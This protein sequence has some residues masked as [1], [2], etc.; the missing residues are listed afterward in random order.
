VNEANK[1]RVAK[2]MARG[3]KALPW[4]SFAVGLITGTIMDR[5]PER[6]PFVA[7]AAG[8]GWFAVSA[9]LI[10]GK[11]IVPRLDRRRALA[12]KLIEFSHYSG[13]QTITQLC[14]FFSFPFYLQA[15]SLRVDH[16]IFLVLLAAVAFVSLWDPLY[17]AV[18]ARTWAR[19]PVQ[20]FA[21]FAG[22]NCALPILGLS[23]RV[24]L[25]ASAFFTVAGSPLI[26]AWT[27]KRMKLQLAAGAV[28]PFLLL[29]GASS[30]VPPAP[31]GLTESKIGTRI[32]GKQLVDAT[33]TF[34]AP[35]AQLACFTAVRAPRGLRDKLLHVWRQNGI[36][37]DRVPLE[38]VGG[39]EGGYRTWSI[40]KKLG[41]DPH[42]RWTCTVETAIGQVLGRAAAT[43]DGP[44]SSR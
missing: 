21:T 10:A 35:P 44:P 37:V 12:E 23:N 14:V 24:S 34:A 36:E 38:V 22:L 9:I 17:E 42:G 27:K 13:L 43:I 32:E 29:I 25:Y 40:K 20:A 19:A 15:A 30:A 39:R 11:V 28:I 1:A 18:L 41:K 33:E 6:A 26:A 2:W 4:A 3:R 8:I 5:R 31:L 7:L 16:A